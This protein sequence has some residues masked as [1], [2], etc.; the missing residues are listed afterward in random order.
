MTNHGLLP[1]A[2]E[3]LHEEEQER[4]RHREAAIYAAANTTRTWCDPKSHTEIVGIDFGAGKMH[5]HSLLS[6]RDIASVAL[7]DVADTLA[8]FGVGALVVGEPA[9]LAVPQT[10]KSLAQPF[11]AEGLLK[12]YD[13]CERSGVTLRLFPH[14]HSRKARVWAARNAE[15]GFVD[16]EKT[17]DLND[18]RA[19]A[20]FVAH[21]NGVSLGAPPRSFRVVTYRL[22]GQLVRRR[23]N[24]VL[25][26][27]KTFGYD[28]E[29]FSSVAGMARDLAGAF[30]WTPNFVTHKVAF[31]IAS[32][33]I[34]ESGGAAHR[35]TYRNKSPGASAWMNYIAGFSDRHHRGGV[36]RANMMRDR[37]RPF[38]SKYAEMNGES[39][40]VGNRYVGFGELTPR[41]DQL[42]R[43]AWKAVRMQV[44]AAYRAAVA[45]SADLP[46]CELLDE[47]PSHGR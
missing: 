13:A 42:R 2:A 29:V 8:S 41:Q 27:A 43:E 44:R 34:G 37:F 5:C 3:A 20:Y 28:G 46:G 36:A 24:R 25:M 39:I 6:G 23:S 10:E 47:E 12:I 30:E 31:S 26:A 4:K 15:P 18:A 7:K 9:H 33:V 32:L 1:F 11:T 17:S 40:K 38:F 19:I 35:F 22:Y 21:N 14:A 16:E 45:M